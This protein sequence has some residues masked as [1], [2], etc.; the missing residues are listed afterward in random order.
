MPTYPGYRSIVQAGSNAFGGVAIIHRNALKC[1]LVERDVNVLIVEIEIANAQLKIGAIYVPPKSS[2]PLSLMNKYKNEPF[3][4]FGDYNAKHSHWNCPKNNKTGN[5]LL[6]WVEQ[7]GTEV[8]APTQATSRRSDSIIDFG[9]THD[10]Q[11]WQI[12]VLDEGTSDH[13]PIL[14]QSSYCAE[15]ETQF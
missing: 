13:K 15:E 4:Y 8:I 11:G 12:E 1:R 2:L 3:I 7:T 6:N 9:I 5:E 10:A 14:F